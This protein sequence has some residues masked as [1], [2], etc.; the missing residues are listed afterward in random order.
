MHYAQGIVQRHGSAGTLNSLVKD[1]VVGSKKNIDPGFF[2]G[3]GQII[4]RRKRRI[5]RIGGAA[6]SRLHVQNCKICIPEPVP[7]ICI[8]EG[9]NDWYAFKYFQEV[10]LK[11]KKPIH[12]YPGAGATKLDTIIGLYLA[13]GKNF[14]VV[15]DGDSEGKDA[16][17]KYQDEFGPVTEGKLFTLT[18]ASG[19]N[20]ATEKMIDDDSKKSLTKAAFGKESTGKKAVNQAINKLL[21]EGKSVTIT[22]DTKD[23][24]R[25][26][27]KFVQAKLSR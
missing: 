25:K 12:F 27:F 4:G 3:Y 7:D 23:N 24:F 2:G 10:I 11:S 21:A 22:K 19:V 18:D 8:T 20:G 26:L 17:G 5:P 15:I 6:V 14:I 1:M 9:K 13:W 16:I